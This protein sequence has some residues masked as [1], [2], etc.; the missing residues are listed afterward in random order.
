MVPIQHR[1]VGL[2]HLAHRSASEDRRVDELIADH[3]D[4]PHPVADWAPVLVT[5]L[6][7]TQ[8]A[9]LS[10]QNAGVPVLVEN[11][12]VPVMW[13]MILEEPEA[14]R[15]DGPDEHRPETI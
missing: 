9:V 6:V 12:V 3:I 14:V 5:Q 15:M 2:V 1:S 4:C 13:H 10:A 8:V 7:Q 11:V